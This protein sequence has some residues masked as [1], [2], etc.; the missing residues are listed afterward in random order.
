VEIIRIGYA[1]WV[2][3]TIQHPHQINWT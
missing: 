1:D 2:A 3:L